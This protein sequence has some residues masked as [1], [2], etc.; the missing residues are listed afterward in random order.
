MHSECLESNYIAS[1]PFRVNAVSF[2]FKFDR[3]L[4]LSPTK[5]LFCLSLAP[6]EHVAV[7]VFSN[8]LM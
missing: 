7:Y 2:G 8:V 4:V 3:G 5:S 6:G 1:R